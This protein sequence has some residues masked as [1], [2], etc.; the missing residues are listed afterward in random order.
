MHKYFNTTGICIPRKH[1]MV[2]IDNKL[3]AIKKLIDREQYFVINRPRQYGKTTTFH[4]LELNLGDEYLVVSISFEG[5]G[6]MIF[7]DETLL[8][9]G[10]LQLIA[11]DLEIKD[12]KTA[13][14]LKELLSYTN[15]LNDLSKS[16]TNFIKFSN[17]EVILLIDEVD[18]SSNNQLFLSFLGVLR[19]KYLLREAGKDYTF[20]S[21]ILAGV[22]D[23]KSLK[24]KLRD[25][26]EQKYNSPWNIA[27]DFEVDMSFNSYE[28]ETM[29]NEYE[30]CNNISMDIRSLSDRIYY[31]TNGY[32]FLVSRVCQII[33]EKIY[34]DNKKAWDL[35]DIDKSVK[36]L[37]TE[38]NTLFESLVKNLENNKE[39]YE[40]VLRILI[41]GEHIVFNTLDPLINLGV[42][43]GFIREGSNGVEVS[44]KIFQE[45]IYNYM[46][47]KIQT[48]AKNISNYNFKQNFIQ[49]NGS[50]DFTKIL[51]RFQQFM[52][53]QYSEKDVTFLE[54]NGRTLFLAFLKPIINGTGFD[55]KE[56]QVSEE[57]R[58]D[59]VVTYNEFKY[60]VELKIWRGQKYHDKGILQLIDYLNIH[61]LNKGY[62]IIFNFNK[63]K[64]YKSEML[65]IEDKEIVLVYV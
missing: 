23:V 16:I 7:N 56:V 49:D 59:V 57:K 26:E 45:I 58:L 60:I 25:N 64:E 46:V 44:N 24:L 13:I 39:L 15:N 22:Y 32:P 1:Y 47:S 6:D 40:L 42:T 18:K 17:K 20:K 10:I 31:F 48:R 11:D 38:A 14:K 30:K 8:A 4:Q 5:I 41:N 21:V 2:N 37:T 63:N 33:D 55:F 65:K 62:L 9:R 35:G 19:N 28:I 50:L 52:K 34:R 12:E 61:G 3:Q 27:V 54:Y 51:E 43:Y 53:E 29:L 36:I